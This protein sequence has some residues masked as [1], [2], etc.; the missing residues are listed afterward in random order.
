MEGRRR[1]WRWTL[2]P[3]DVS[4]PEGRRNTIA[5]LLALCGILFLGLIYAIGVTTRTT[6]RANHASRM[7]ASAVREAD[8][9][10]IR[11]EATCRETNLAR[12][13]TNHLRQ[14][15]RDFELQAG[16]LLV[17]RGELQYG[18]TWIRQA[19]EI[20]FL[21]TIDCETGQATQFIAGGPVPPTPPIPDR[22]TR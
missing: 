14:I 22:S 8:A 10:A 4:T 6:N 19:G 18:Q 21:T 16:V 1:F 9:V 20:T 2:P 12:A 15:Q 5:I 13:A 11:F 3:L 17:S 7:A